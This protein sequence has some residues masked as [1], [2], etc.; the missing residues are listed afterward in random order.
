M[1][2][3]SYSKNIAPGLF[4]ILSELV[5]NNVDTKIINN[6]VKIMNDIKPPSSNDYYD[7]IL[8][9]VYS[10]LNRLDLLINYSDGTLINII[11]EFIF[12][13]KID[14]EI[15]RTIIHKLLL[16]ISTYDLTNIFKSILFSISSESKREELIE[17]IKE[18]DKK[19]NDI[20][21][22]VLLKGT[23]LPEDIF[24]NIKPFLF[25]NK[26]QRSIK[27]KNKRRIFKK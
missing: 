21:I 17:I 16:N 25:G 18:E 11:N 14:T 2:R 13:K 4:L 9:L 12:D 7:D 8:I 10:K 5:E 27:R 19:I 15:F 24:S 20:R 6:I 1:E 22:D 26:R 3:Y 23:T